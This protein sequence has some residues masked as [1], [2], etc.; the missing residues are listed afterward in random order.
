VKWTHQLLVYADDVNT[1]G[2][3]TNITEEIKRVPLSANTKI[4]LDEWAAV[5]QPAQWLGY[6]LDE[7]GSISCQDWDFFSSPR[8]RD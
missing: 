6:G 1:L 3:N 8:H 5:A 4:S 7:Q 2:E